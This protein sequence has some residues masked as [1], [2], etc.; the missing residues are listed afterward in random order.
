MQHIRAFQRERI[1][2]QIKAFFS[3]VHNISDFHYRLYLLGNLCRHCDGRGY[4]NTP[5]EVYPTC[6]ASG[7]SDTWRRQSPT[8]QAD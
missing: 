5:E 1:V 7:R 2:E 4:V 6:H 3:G 8:E